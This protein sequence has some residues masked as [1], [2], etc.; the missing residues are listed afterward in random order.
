MGEMRVEVAV[1][2]LVQ[3]PDVFATGPRPQA[4]RRR[5]AGG[6][7]VE[8]IGGLLQVAADF[9]TAPRP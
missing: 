2:Q 6:V 9:T 1:G 8:R 7:K 3:H 5:I 4:Q